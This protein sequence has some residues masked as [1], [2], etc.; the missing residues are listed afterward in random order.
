MTSQQSS[1]KRYLITGATGFLGR[2]LVEHLLNQRP[3]MQ[4]IP[5]VRN[6]LAW[7]TQ[8]WVSAL[9]EQEVLTGILSDVKQPEKQAE[10]GQLDGIFHLAALVRH[11]R[12]NS[13][14][15]YTT[16]IE[17]T[18]DMVRLAAAKQCRLVY[19]ST[20]GTVGVFDRRQQWADEHSAFQ[21][22]EIAKWPY[23]DSKLKAER[24][25]RKLADKLGVE[26]VIIRPPVMLGP[27]DHRFRS[28]G[29][30]I[31][32]LR[33]KLPF[34]IQG[35]MH[36]VDIRDAA[37]AL[38]SAMRLDKP[39]PVYHLSGV[40]CSIGNFFRMVKT[41]SG[42]DG[43]KI[44]LPH[45][46]AMGLARLGVGLAKIVPGMHESPLP[47]PVVV[48]MA[49]K[50][51]DIRSRYAAQDLGFYNRHGQDTI[52]DTVN[53]LIQHHPKLGHLTPSERV[54]RHRPLALK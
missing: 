50:F 37:A 10:L 6:R 54:K 2:H 33:G 21:D 1:P 5:L 13:E 4:P 26:L 9:P 36:F 47:D 28:T 43:P 16:N 8:D 31:R 25:A 7:D 52:D 39:Q 40:A 22:A 34:L 49:G 11:S 14:D 15:V 53:W 20:S 17:G 48:E 24:A 3:D 38:A 41:A 46:M 42:V 30:I 51:W 27:G 23:Y 18:L 32:Y 44:F 12:A 29:H 19:V 35:G 45:P